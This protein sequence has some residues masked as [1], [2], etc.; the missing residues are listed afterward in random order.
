M[1]PCFV[2]NFRRKAFDLSLLSMMLAVGFFIDTF[3]Q[4]EEV[5]SIPS[6][7]RIF[8]HE[9]ILDVVKKELI[10]ACGVTPLDC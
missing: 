9:W 2:P 5:P 3:H 1:T 10:G 6:A 4:I 8:Y 7:L